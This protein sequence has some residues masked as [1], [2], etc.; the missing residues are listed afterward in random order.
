MHLILMTDALG[1]VLETAVGRCQLARFEPLPA[2]TI[3]GQLAAEGVPEERAEAC[4]RLA[5][6]NASRAR[7]LGV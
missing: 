3:A 1:R 6:G 2:A 5:L 7:Y 4:A